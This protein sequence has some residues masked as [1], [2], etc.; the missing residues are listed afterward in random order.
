[1][2]SNTY[3][4]AFLAA[5]FSLND[6]EIQKTKDTRTDFKTHRMKYD[7]PFNREKFNCRNLRRIHNIGQPQW[8][9]YSH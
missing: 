8:R 3:S 1:M 6:I 2:T 4:N 7:K 5:L 9:G